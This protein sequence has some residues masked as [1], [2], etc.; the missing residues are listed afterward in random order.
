L[1]SENG[2]KLAVTLIDAFEIKELVLLMVSDLISDV[3]NQ[4]TRRS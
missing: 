4:F 3:H 1:Q 2:S